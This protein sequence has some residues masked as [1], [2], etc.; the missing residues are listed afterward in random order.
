MAINTTLTSSQGWSPD[1]VAF[2]PREAIPEALILRASTV[3]TEQL[4][5]DAPAAR[6]PWVDDAAADFFA[7]GTEITESDPALNE[8]TVYTGKIAQLIRVSREQYAQHTTADL[9]AGSVSR[10]IT[11]RAN[12]AFISQPT[13][14]SGNTP[15]AGLLNAPGIIAGGT[16][17]ANLDPLAEVV[18]S[19]ES[20]GGSPGVIIANP[21][22]FANLRTLKTATDANSSLLGAGTEDQARRL[23]GI[24]VITSPAVPEGKMLVVDPTAV[25]SAV[26]PV[27]VATSTERYFE[28]DAVGLRA[29]WRLGWSVQHADRIGSVD[30]ADPT[31]A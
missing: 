13:P 7:E 28:S 10:A 26:G 29:T 25:A 27:Q 22:A 19:I 30:V 15:P 2:G 5:G 24:E 16:I 17:D 31:A 20:A 14:G 21:S 23:L 12:E 18:G 8:V 4:E 3:V 9:L 11:R 6:V 1:L